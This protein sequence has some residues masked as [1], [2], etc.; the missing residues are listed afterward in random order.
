MLCT[1]PNNFINL[2]EQYVNSFKKNSSNTCFFRKSYPTSSWVVFVIWQQHFEENSV[3]NPIFCE[4]C[5]PEQHFEFFLFQDSIFS[6]SSAL[7]TISLRLARTTRL[8]RST[9][10]TPQPC[11][12]SARWCA[13]SRS[14]CPSCSEHSESNRNTI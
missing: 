3:F 10:P 12:A 8:R 6:G 5:F 14:R 9:C 11:A 13:R 4:S 1:W 7:L 2:L